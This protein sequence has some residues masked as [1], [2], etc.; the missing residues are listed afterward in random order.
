SLHAILDRRS[1]GAARIDG[2]SA[3]VRRSQRWAKALLATRPPAIP[4]RARRVGAEI[5]TRNA[6]SQRCFD[7]ASIYA[8]IAQHITRVHACFRRRRTHAPRRFRKARRGRWH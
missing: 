5:Q 7:H 6:L 1:Y 4:E 3:L 8:P 2:A